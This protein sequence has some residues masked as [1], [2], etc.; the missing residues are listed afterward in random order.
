MMRWFAMA[1]LLACA[2]GDPK[3]P[4]PETDEQRDAAE[5]LQKQHDYFEEFMTTGRQECSKRCTMAHAVCE[6][7]RR[8]C[9][10]AEQSPKQEDALAIIDVIENL[11]NAPLLR[12]VALAGLLFRDVA[13]KRHRL[14]ELCL[15]HAE[16]VI[17]LDAVDVSEINRGCLV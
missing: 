16:D 17:A 1:L 15:K 13:Q 10:I 11:A 4:P 7:T 3:L 6:K 2:H 14:L 5:E 12:L 8:I 9:S